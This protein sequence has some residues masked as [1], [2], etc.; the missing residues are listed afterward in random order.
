MV[1]GTSDDPPADASN[2]LPRSDQLTH[3]EAQLLISKAWDGEVTAREADLLTLHL[4][5]CKAC[6][7]SGTE[8][9]RVLR[10]IDYCLKLRRDEGA[11]ESRAGEAS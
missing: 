11:P 7:E 6:A 1:T 9:A 8:M 2:G 3:D 10:R 5:H 4:Q